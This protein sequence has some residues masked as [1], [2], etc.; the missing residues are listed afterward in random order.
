MLYRDR[1]TN[2]YSFLYSNAD[3]VQIVYDYLIL[4]INTSAV[5]VT[6]YRIT[7]ISI[8]PY[9]KIRYSMKTAQEIILL[10]TKYPQPGRSK[11][12]LI[13]A[14]GAEKAAAIQR[15]MTQFILGNISQYIDKFLCDLAIYFDGGTNELMNNWL[16]DKYRYVEQ[17]NSDLG[18]R[19]AM[20]VRDHQRKYK[21]VVIIGSDSPDINDTVIQQAFLKLQSHEIVIGPA[22]D[23]GYYLIGMQT[24][25]SDEC[26]DCLFSDIAWGSAAVLDQT[27][28]RVEQQKLRYHLLTRLHDIDTPEDLRY[29]DNNPDT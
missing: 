20:A 2:V 1:R 22:Y 9:F 10:F 12:R 29:F 23:G 6:I 13:P 11:T 28:T 5:L 3:M 14:V 18:T 24:Q 21:A 19:M 27:I 7:V 8:L 25:L 17:I 4:T 15:Q 16:G 26:I